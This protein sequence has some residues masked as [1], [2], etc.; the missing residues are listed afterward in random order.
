[1]K[2][3]LNCSEEV[4]EEGIKCEH[5]M[6]HTSNNRIFW[7]SR[8]RVIVVGIILLLVVDLAS[9][10]YLNSQIKQLK[11]SDESRISQKTISPEE[12]SVRDAFNE[13]MNL[14]L[15]GNCDVFADSV[16][17]S[18]EKARENWGERC[19]KEKVGEMAPI[20]D[21]VINRLSIKDDKAFIQANLTRSIDLGENVTYTGTYDL[22]L[23]D[24]KWKLIS[25]KDQK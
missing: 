19:R 3:C 25:P 12:K 13:S 23:E 8:S 5:C 1:M 20:S 10:V 2:K 17:K 18:D 14:R 15:V 11:Q 9:F 4:S 7:L 6:G 16:S 21:I 22:K 24:G